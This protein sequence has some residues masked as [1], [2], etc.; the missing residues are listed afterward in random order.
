MFLY[1]THVVSFEA[2]CNVL[3]PCVFTACNMLLVLLLKLTPDQTIQAEINSSDLTL[4]N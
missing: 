2:I 1:H 3:S 4:E